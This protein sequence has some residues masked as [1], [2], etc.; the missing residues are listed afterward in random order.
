MIGAISLHS[1][2]SS[3]VHFTGDIHRPHT[4]THT[5]TVHTHFLLNP[6]SGY[7]HTHF[8]SPQTQ[9]AYRALYAE[10]IAGAQFMM[11][12]CRPAD[13]TQNHP[14]EFL[15]G[16]LFSS[17]SS[18]DPLMLNMSN[19]SVFSLLWMIKPNRISHVSI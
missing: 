15:E 4:H 16:L 3:A 8:T 19:R 2:T 1:H 12:L 14:Q 11:K 9:L 5:D 6:N 7:P 13:S 17:F 18:F 10:G